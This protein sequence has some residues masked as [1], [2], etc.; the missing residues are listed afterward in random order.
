M[1]EVYAK[2]TNY[3]P[4]VFAAY[5]E[6]SSALVGVLLAV[7]Q[8]EGNAVIGFFSKRIVI[9]GGPLILGNDPNILKGLLSFFKI[10]IQ[11]KA[12]YTVFRN[13]WSW[14]PMREIFEECGF[15]YEPQL[16]IHISL[17]IPLEEVLTRISKNKLRNTAKAENKGVTLSECNDIHEFKESLKVVYETYKRVKIPAPHPSLFIEAFNILIDKKY[18]KIFLAKIDTTII[19]TRIVFT[20]NNKIFDWYAGSSGN[21]SNKY[22]NDYL[23]VNILKWGV[24]NNF[25]MFDF[26]GAGNPNIP[27]GVRDHKM[28]FGGDLHEF[29]RFIN[30]NNPLIYKFATHVYKIYKLIKT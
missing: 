20:F 22:P 11:N 19:G 10:K 2:T 5:E 17:N 9:D 3:K 4:L 14:A 21:E 7:L 26:G 16:D 29:G 28:K 25:S 8:K 24:N 18:L 27:Y 1:S 23:L 13:Y 6:E 30:I 12:L 15:H